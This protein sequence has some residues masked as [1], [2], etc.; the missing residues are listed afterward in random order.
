MIGSTGFEREGKESHRSGRHVG[1]LSEMSLMQRPLKK[2]PE[3]RSH[4]VLT[5]GFVRPRTDGSSQ[6]AEAQHGL[7]VTRGGHAAR[8][9]GVLIRLA[10]SGAC[11]LATLVVC[12]AATSACG[13]ATHGLDGMQLKVTPS[14]LAAYTAEQAAALDVGLTASIKLQLMFDDHVSGRR[15]NVET[16]DRVVT[17]KG[18]IDTDKEKARATRIAR[19]TYGLHG[20]STS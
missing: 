15:I 9:D 17:L 18:V 16:K 11:A 14:E 13:P 20:S 4:R 3:G 1:K 2:A 10:L 6:Q 8:R 7:N 5:A 12:V 19:D